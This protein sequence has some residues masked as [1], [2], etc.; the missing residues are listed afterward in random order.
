MKRVIIK[1][2]F[3]LLAFSCSRYLEGAL[4][5]PVIDNG[6]VTF[7]FFSPSARTVQVA[8]DWNNW[9]RGDAETGEV[10]VGLMNKNEKDG[11]WQI[12]CQLPAGRYRY[13]FIIDETRRVLDPVNPRVTE[14]PWG[15]KANLLVVP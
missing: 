14:D 8:G 6:A 5:S 2:I 1:V 9:A 15:G 3:L 7:R 11:I 10:L 12:T 4:E 13:S